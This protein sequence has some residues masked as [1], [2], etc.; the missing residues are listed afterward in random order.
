METIV[1]KSTIIKY[2]VRGFAIT[3]FKDKEIINFETCEENFNA[4]LK[5]SGAKPL[6][7]IMIVGEQNVFEK[8]LYSFYGTSLFS[9]YNLCAVMVAKSNTYK[10]IFNFFVRIYRLSFPLIFSTTYDE[11]E[12][13]I[14]NNLSK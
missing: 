14:L 5:L 8:S 11:A 6:G 13:F 3:Q 9:N 10:L 4:S 12:K 2:N 1:T 7:N